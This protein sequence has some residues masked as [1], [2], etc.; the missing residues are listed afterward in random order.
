M[1][2]LFICFFI[3]FCGGVQAEESEYKTDFSVINPQ[4]AVKPIFLTCVSD[5]KS[6]IEHYNPTS[7]W[8]LSLKSKQIAEYSKGNYV[9]YNSKFLTYG[10]VGDYTE[11]IEKEGGINL[12]HRKKI[13]F[14]LKS[15]DLKLEIRVVKRGAALTID[16]ANKTFFYKCKEDEN[17]N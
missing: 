4:I 17:L 12:G 13:D 3:L 8:L 15:Y 14:N 10:V 11:I 5:E 16:I 9:I 6:S 1:K 7:R 2:K